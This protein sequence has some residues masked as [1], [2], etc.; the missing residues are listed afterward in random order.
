MRPNVV[1]GLELSEWGK[2]KALFSPTIYSHC[3][4]KMALKITLLI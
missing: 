3:L 2:G 4:V 1:S